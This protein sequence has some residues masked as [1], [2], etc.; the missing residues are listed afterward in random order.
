[1]NPFFIPFVQLPLLNQKDLPVILPE[2]VWNNLVPGEYFSR[3]RSPLK[4][5]HKIWKW[6]KT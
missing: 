5:A 4:G 6:K 2:E 1:M 3:F